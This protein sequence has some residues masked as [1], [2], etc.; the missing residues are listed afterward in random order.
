M[1]S[2]RVLGPAGL[3]NPP[4]S[5]RRKSRHGGA[6]RVEEVRAKIIPVKAKV[7]QEAGGC[8]WRR[9]WQPTPV[10]LPREPQELRGLVGCRL[11]PCRGILGPGH[12]P[13]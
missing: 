6:A 1:D 11:R 8:G 2:W 10:F 12:S 13:K 7:L 4:G 3:P 9:K 5:P